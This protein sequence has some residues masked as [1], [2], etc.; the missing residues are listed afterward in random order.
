MFKKLQEISTFG[1]QNARPLWS[2]YEKCRR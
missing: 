1:D 2:Q